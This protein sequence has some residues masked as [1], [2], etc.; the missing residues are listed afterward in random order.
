MAQKKYYAVAVGEKPGVYTEWF[1]SNGAEIQIK[2]FP[3]ARYK[4]FPTRE[5]A[6][7]FIEKNFGK[8]P[9][10]RSGV[11]FSSAKTG[12]AAEKPKSAAARKADF[13]I[14]TDGGCLNNPGPGGYGV[15]I[16]KGKTTREFSGGFQL[17]T[18]NRMELMACIV[19]LSQL[20]KPYRVTIYSDSKY[21]VNG[22]TKGWAAK[23]KLNGWVKSDKKPAL[24]RDLWNQLLSLCR[25]HDVEFVWVKG[26]AGNAGNERC[27]QLATEAM[28]NKD[29]PADKEY[30]KSQ[31]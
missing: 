22:I 29:L 24:N 5:E 14:H 12:P 23:W 25:K 26:H 27:D 20:K 10:K 16:S 30:L 18:N 11:K 15:V 3:G 7:D 1:G 31:Y 6:E 13:T 4:G 17:T 2:G 9:A 8:K 19:G 28:A 21:V